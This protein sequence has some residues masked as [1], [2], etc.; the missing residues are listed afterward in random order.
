MN[1]TQLV[2][3]VGIIA[4]EL[5]ESAG[6]GDLEAV[7]RNRD[8]RVS[9][10]RALLGAGCVAIA[11]LIIGFV[12]SRIESPEVV[13][14]ASQ[15]DMREN[16]SSI[17]TGVDG[18]E[19]GL[20]GLAVDYPPALDCGNSPGGAASFL[21]TPQTP[22]F[23]SQAEAVADFLGDSLSVV[24]GFDPEIPG[25]IAAV[26]ADGSV[27]IHIALSRLNGGWVVSGTVGC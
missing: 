25:F 18:E 13:E 22:S 15:S 27:R 1:N 20:E 17:E 3:E 23:D 6:P 24:P 12:P 19:A 26:D 10:R 7:Y 16:G 21:L 5:E 8:R 9:Q 4:K 2:N 11:A 14:S